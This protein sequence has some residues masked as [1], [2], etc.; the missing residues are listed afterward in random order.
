MAETQEAKQMTTLT[1]L[2]E[3]AEQ[4]LELAGETWRYQHLLAVIERQT[5]KAYQDRKEAVI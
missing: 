1:Q 2:F 3:Q 4:E 5:W